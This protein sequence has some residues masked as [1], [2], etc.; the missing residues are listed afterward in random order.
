MEIDQKPM[1]CGMS[2]NY[3]FTVAHLEIKRPGTLLPGTDTLIPVTC[4]EQAYS[5][6]VGLEVADQGLAVVTLPETVIS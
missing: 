4:Q 3:G 6:W 2:C 1:E 5:L